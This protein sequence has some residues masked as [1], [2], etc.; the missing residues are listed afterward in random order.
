[1]SHCSCP[2][3]LLGAVMFSLAACGTGEQ[4]SNG[5][6]E[7]NKA[8]GVDL[9]FVGR[10]PAY[11]IDMIASSQ[12]AQTKATD[13]DIRDLA[14]RIIQTDTDIDRQLTTLA[15]TEGLFLPSGMDQK[16]QARLVQI[17]STN[18]PAFNRAWLDQALPDQTMAIEAFQ[19]EAD[20]GTYPPFR[21]LA[22]QSLPAMLQ[23][24]QTTQQLSANR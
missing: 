21:N 17:Q 10:A 18:G 14:A 12:L 13:S 19:A 7:A 22:E 4:A 2:A 24:L 8:S 5:A 11:N 16:H 23:N 15:Q 20:K 9:N 6:P 3:L 1:M